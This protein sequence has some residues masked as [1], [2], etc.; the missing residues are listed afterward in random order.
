MKNI[1]TCCI[2]LLLTTASYAQKQ[3][4]EL[5]LVKGQTYNQR[6]A[7]DMTMIQNM[8][9]QDLNI[10]I[11]INALMSYKVLDQLDTVYIISC[12]YE[13]LSMK[14]E[15]PNNT[16]SVD[17][18][19]PKEGDLLSKMMAGMKKNTFTMKMT[20]KGRIVEV[21]GIEKLFEGLSEATEL[22]AAQLAQLKAQLSQSYGEEAFKANMEMSMAV[23]PKIA[24]NVGEKWI[25][26]GKLKSGMTADIETT[27][28]LK[29]VTS[30][31]YLITGISK[32]T[33]T[34]K[35]V[36]VNNGMKMIYHITGDMT[37]NIKISKIT[38]WMA[39]A[40]IQQHIKGHTEIPPTAQLPDGLSLPMDM[41]NKMTLS[42]Q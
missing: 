11:G 5:S 38:G 17:S 29:D 39:N 8:Q 41:S 26:K 22:P 20:K 4:I 9:G 30:D 36:N 12:K 3:K 6:L 25:T 24:V 13:S 21:K 42:E 15:M 7:S 32:I 18:E 2:A 33:T 19:N 16:M 35:D 37:S 1:I 34:G 40:V 14:M 27:Y 28:T 31:Y 10:K 23:Y